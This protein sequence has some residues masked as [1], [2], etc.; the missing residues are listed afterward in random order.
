MNRKGEAKMVTSEAVISIL[1]IVVVIY[2]A[3]F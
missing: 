2:M 1:I 3:S